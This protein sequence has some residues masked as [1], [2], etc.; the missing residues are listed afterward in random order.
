MMV[1]SQ[2]H[3]PMFAAA[4]QLLHIKIHQILPVPI[5][6]AQSWEQPMLRGAACAAIPLPYSRWR[7]R[8]PSSC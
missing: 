8:G 1:L 7:T 6:Y 3:R 5:N 4:P 2:E